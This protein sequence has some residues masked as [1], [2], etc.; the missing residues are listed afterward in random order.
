MPGQ[1]RPVI[2]SASPET[3]DVVDGQLSGA[4]F[5]V[6]YRVENFDKVEQP[7][8]KLQLYARGIG[9]LVTMDVPARPEGAERLILDSRHNV[10][11]PIRFRANCPAGTTNWY[12]LGQNP[13][14]LEQRISDT[15]L[16]ANA[17]P[18][19]IP[20]PQ[21]E[22]PGTVVQVSV[23]GKRLTPDCTIEAQVNRSPVELQN[24]HY[25]DKRFQGLLRR[26]DFGNSVVTPRFLEMKL[27]LHGTKT[28]VEAIK[29]ILFREPE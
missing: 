7:T 12:T 8:M 13:P 1:I 14:P 3:V 26:D 18:E 17:A 10:G 11:P 9:T 21:T 5:D 20:S 22:Q 25:F 24:V 23:F 2:V 4:V 19:F 28:G 27:I 15:L 29:R 6:T 16:V